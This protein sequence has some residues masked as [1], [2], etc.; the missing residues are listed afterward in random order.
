MHS[1]LVIN[2]NTLLW[3]WSNVH[4]GAMFE[5]LDANDNLMDDLGG[6]P[7]LNG[8]W[9]LLHAVIDP[10]VIF[11]RLCLF[12]YLLGYLLRLS[13]SLCLQEVRA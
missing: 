3:L 8:D 12:M 1:F 13:V 4:D 10:K 11:V 6:T 9:K 5:V 2:D 7:V